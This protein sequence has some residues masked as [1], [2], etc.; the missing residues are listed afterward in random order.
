M[1]KPLPNV[2]ENALARLVPGTTS[3]WDNGEI[4]RVRVAPT[5][6]RRPWRSTVRTVFQLALALATLLPFVASGVYDDIDQA[7]VIVGQVLAAAATFTRVM[8]MTEVEGFLRR[9]APWLAA[10]PAAK[11]EG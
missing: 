5:Q 1:K 2:A 6:V 4:A 9:W 11:T 7:P 3:P 10:A 8:A